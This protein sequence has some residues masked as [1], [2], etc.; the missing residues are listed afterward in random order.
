MSPAIQSPAIYNV[1]VNSVAIVSDAIYLSRMEEAA[2]NPTERTG[3]KGLAEHLCFAIY[4]AHHAFNRVYKPALDA[5]GLTYPQ[6][7]ALVLL[8]DEDDQTVGGLGDKLFLQ[9]N[10]LT[11]L[12][13]R[14]E[15]LG[16]VERRRDPVDERQVRIRLTAQGSALRSGAECLPD[17]IRLAAGLSVEELLAMSDRVAAMRDRLVA[18]GH[19]DTAMSDPGAGA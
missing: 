7:L 9:S 3:G 4:S 1:P 16:H 10:T 11:P 14:L 2:P 19:A 18:A 12:L 17:D 15:A 8:W 5:L 13:K 6:Y